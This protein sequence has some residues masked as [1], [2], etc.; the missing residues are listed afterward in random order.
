M[1]TYSRTVTEGGLEYK[2][3]ENDFGD[4]F[5]SYKGRRHRLLGP[6][7]E[8]HN[9]KKEWYFMGVRI[10]CSSQEKFERIIKLKAFW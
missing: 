4:K 8:M 6:A 9:G 3:T 5:W 7:I 2:Y 1:T 10:D